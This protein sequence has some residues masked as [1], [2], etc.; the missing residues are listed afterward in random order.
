[1][2]TL[3]NKCKSKQFEDFSQRYEIDKI[4]EVPKRE[5]LRLMTEQLR[6]K[7]FTRGPFFMMRN[8]PRDWALS[9]LQEQLATTSLHVSRCPQT[10]EVLAFSLCT[11]HT[12]EA[13]LRCW[14]EFYSP[15]DGSHSE[16]VIPHM[17]Y[18]LRE[19]ATTEHGDPQVILTY[20]M[21]VYVG[22]REQLEAL[23]NDQLGLSPGRIGEKPMILLGCSLSDIFAQSSK[24]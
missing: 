7:N 16:L 6:F 12:I 13:G 23:V 18:H 1:M 24:L 17:L 14:L 15:V 3:K 5:A 8:Q 10:R 19:L 22:N 21:P 4:V 9:T 20:T 2:K 11:L